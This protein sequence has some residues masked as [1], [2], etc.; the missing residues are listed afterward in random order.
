MTG[1]PRVFL[2]YAWE[3]DAYCERVQKL[4]DALRRDDIDARMDSQHL[5][6]RRLTRF[7]NSEIRLAHKICVLC[8]PMMRGK[9]EATEDGKTMTGVGWEVGQVMGQIFHG[10]RA[11]EDV[12][13]VLMRGTAQSAIPSSLRDKPYFDLSV[14]RQYKRNYSSLRETLRANTGPCG[15]RTM[16]KNALVIAGLV[17]L[18]LGVPATLGGL[19]LSGR[20]IVPTGDYFRTGDWPEWLETLRSR[21]SRL[22]ARLDSSEASSGTEADQLRQDTRRFLTMLE[23][24]IKLRNLILGGAEVRILTGPVGRDPDRE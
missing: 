10:E 21:S 15:R 3:D 9:V 18:V 8:S 19:R 4:C 1:Q 22:K 7:M 23:A 17:G 2:S 12:V 11:D 13:V 5:Q 6:G 14:R 24:D 20:D 16:G